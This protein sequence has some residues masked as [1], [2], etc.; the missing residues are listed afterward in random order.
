VDL[1]LGSNPDLV[2]FVSSMLVF[3]TGV[4][5]DLELRARPGYRLDGGDTLADTL[6]HR[7]SASK[8]FLLGVE[9]ADGRRSSSRG[10]PFSPARPTPEDIWLSPSGGGGGGSSSVSSGYFLSPLPP[11][12][13]VTFHFV[14]PQ[15][16]I[17]ETV[18]TVSGSDILDAATR[19]R[20]LWPWQ[21]ETEDE[22]EADEFDYDL[23][24]GSWF[25]RPEESS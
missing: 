2:A 14:W 5:F 19:I 24:A 3:S 7:S 20:E 11:P 13:E 1:V 8:G 22:D 25:G 4:Q 10:T 18:A 9:Y 6:F 12:G 16:D 17:P 23:P 21:E 15:A